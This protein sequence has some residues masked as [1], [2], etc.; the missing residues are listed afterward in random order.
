LLDEL[1]VGTGEATY[2]NLALGPQGTCQ[3]VQ[4]PKDC[5]HSIAPVPEEFRGG[6]RIIA[7]IVRLVEDG[8]L[9]HG[10]EVLEE[11]LAGIGEGGVGQGIEGGAEADFVSG[12][13][14]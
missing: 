4:V 12:E 3:D 8:G 10:D 7:D 14:L 1:F 5:G 13:D 6:N 9:A 2:G 11:A